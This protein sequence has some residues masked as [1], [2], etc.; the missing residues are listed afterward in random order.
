MSENSTNKTDLILLQRSF[1]GAGEPGKGEV[2][3]FLFEQVK[4]SDNAYV[5]SVAPDGVVTHF[6]V[7]KRISHPVCV[8]FERRLY[9]E[10]ERKEAYPKQNAFGVTAWTARSYE[11]AMELFN[12][13]N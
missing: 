10:T 7:F 11:K 3:G 13:L 4:V 8:D 1:V 6:E 12:G 5:Y 9:S 2:G